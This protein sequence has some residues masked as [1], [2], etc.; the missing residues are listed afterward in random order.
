MISLK[1]LNLDSSWFLEWEGNRFIIDPWLVGSEIDGFSWLNEQW[2][3]KEP[4]QMDALPSYDYILLS[5]SYEDHCHINT[6]AEMEAIK[7]ILATPK[8]FNRIQKK[9]PSREHKQ[10]PDYK[11]SPLKLNRLKIW[12]LHPGGKIDPIFFAVIIT[13]ESNQAIFYCPHGFS[14]NEM[15]EA[16]IKQFEI[17]LFITTFTE[18][19]LPAI[20]GGKVNPGMQNVIDLLNVLKPKH[21]INTHDEEKTVKGLVS[22]LA[23]VNYPDYAAYKKINNINFVPLN[24]Y[25]QV[26]FS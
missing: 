8:A 6:L 20:M 15:Q 21:T 13:N 11:Q 9:F 24:D 2:H 17:E 3:I 26:T 7:P 18:F 1:R 25:K 5:Q 16:F 19:K 22:R 23:K 10:I 14:L 12:H 4:I